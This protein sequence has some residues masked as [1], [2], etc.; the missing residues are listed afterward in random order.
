MIYP[1][2]ETVFRPLKEDETL[3]RLEEVHHFRRPYLL[4]VGNFKPHKEVPF[5]IHAYTRLSTFLKEKY[6]LVLAGP[7]DGDYGASLKREVEK[8]ALSRRVVFTD[9]V[10]EEDL[11]SLYGGAELFLFA[12]SDEGFGFPPLEAMACGV[13]VVA[14][15]S[16]SLPEV[17]G[18]AGRLVGPGDVDV[19][20]RAIEELL[21]DD[22]ER[23]R[24]AQR[25]LERVKQFTV[26]RQAEQLLKSVEVLLR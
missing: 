22:S 21:N 15:R 2:V 10:E 7:L 19:F 5:L 4:Y 11:P 16:A 14:T 24:L 26:D 1:G 25:G 3:R 20:S 12:S 23:R 9:Y 13:P 17:I 8:E 18:E 6:Q